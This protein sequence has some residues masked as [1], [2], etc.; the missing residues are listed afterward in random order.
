MKLVRA[1]TCNLNQWA[2]DF[3]GN[4]DRIIASIEVAKKHGSRYRIGPELEISG[5]SCEDHF[6]E[7]DTYTHSWESL[8][9]ILP[10][11]NDIL[12]DIGI[13]VLHRSVH[14]N[15][16][17][18]CLNQKIVLI[19]PKKY[20]ASDGNYR[21]ERFFAAW[22]KHM[23]VE[24]FILPENIQAVTSQV[25]VPFGDAV[26][27]IGDILIGTETCEELFTPN[28]P[29]IQLSLFGVD[30]IGNGSGSHHQLRKLNQRIDLI[31]EA[32]AKGGGAYLYANQQGCDGNRLYFDGCALISVN[33]KIV[34]QGTQFSVYDVEVVTGIIDI[35][36]IRSFRS[37]LPSRAVQATH[38]HPF[39]LAI[40]KDFSVLIP[41]DESLE[42]IPSPPIKVH[43]YSP[44]EEIALGPS[45]W[46][47]DYLRR[48]G[49]SGYFLPL[50]GGA[51]SSSTA[52]MV[53]CMCQLVVK[54]CSP[55]NGGLPR[56][57][58]LR[59][60][61]NIVGEVED[62]NPTSLIKCESETGEICF[63]PDGYIP[64]DPK[65]L[66]H[67]IFFTSYMGTVNSSEQTCQRAKGLAEEI[68]SH[69][70]DVRIDS[71]VGSIQQ[72]FVDHIHKTPKFEIH[73]GSPP[74]DIALQNIQA[75][76]RMLISYMFAQLLLWS[77]GRKGALLVL[78]SA[79][80]DEALRGY[81]T[82]YDCSSADIN[83]IG[84]ISKSDIRRFLAWG[85]TNLGYPTLQGVVDAVPVAE[86]RPLA[87]P[88]N[89]GVSGQIWTQTDEAD[90][91]MTYDDLSEFGRLRKVERCGPVSMFQRLT[92]VWT[93]LQP[94][95][96]ADK[97]KHFF[98][99]YSINR[100]KMTVL[101]PSYH[102]EN[103][104]PEDN[105]YDLR[106][107]LYNSRWPWQFERVDSLA[108]AMQ[109]HKK[110]KL[111]EDSVSNSLEPQAK[112]RSE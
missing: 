77:E 12:C 23:E 59:D 72:F 34:A 9:G 31:S 45:C 3:R 8:E 92:A 112:K 41:Y 90:M 105:R 37:Y 26:V 6:H 29:H 107:F 99:C 43:Y 66:A 42:C 47:W 11:T 13:P 38:S 111:A 85:A 103:Y 19:R 102:A 39:P 109:Q 64:R 110:R 57:N 16:R 33:G 46:L 76:S 24:D 104:S 48:S 86:L 89:G 96:I 28:S 91:G 93:H 83:P 94:T 36:A 80:V 61:R 55:E 2:M 101:T 20:L 88:Q 14:Y 100:H 21:E 22:S 27:Q 56:L 82:K 32:T 68:G 67:R 87:T 4:R 75:R 18:Y 106:Q 74:E 73:G 25:S 62:P 60:V 1:S 97:V 58:V 98:R 71:V 15:C 50:S 79:N 65:E 95:V 5:Y 30:I 81:L 7:G 63:V 70:Y 69:H 78:G 10:Y 49:M 52:A 51:D 84:G 44:E 35:N 54:A 108:Q 53:G 17:V 40:V